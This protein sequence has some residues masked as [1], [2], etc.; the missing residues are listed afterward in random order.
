MDR[1]L[2]TADVARILGLPASRVRSW[3]RRG[4]CTPDRQGRRLAFS[5]RDLVVL[6][7]ARDLIARHVPAT[8]VHTALRELARALP[9]EGHLAELSVFA[10]GGRVAVRDAA[11][12]F[13]ATTGQGLLNFSLAPLAEAVEA[14]DDRRHADASTPDAGTATLA[15]Q[16]G[17]ALEA[18]DPVAACRA[19]GEALELDRDYVDAYVNLG[20]LALEAGDVRDAA[21]LFHEALERSPDDP[22][23]HFNL[24][25]ALEDTAGPGPACAHYERALELDGGFADAHFN[26]AGLYEELG[27]G[28]DALRHYREYRNLVR[29]G[30]PGPAR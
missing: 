18:E 11:G 25:L 6:R 28:A 10:E 5:F 24:A 14:L 9:D 7:A 1:P 22:V 4:F 17:L 15:F 21:R 20:R 16:R 12:A 27:R 19:Y 2:S 29:A 26:L 3:V 13:D 8:R 23:V 30:D